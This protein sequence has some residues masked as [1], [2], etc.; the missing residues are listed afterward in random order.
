MCR[1]RCY[2][3]P[4]RYWGADPLMKDPVVGWRCLDW[5]LHTLLWG[6]IIMGLLM[7]WG[8]EAHRMSR[9]MSH[10]CFWQEGLVARTFDIGRPARRS[11]TWERAIPCS[12]KLAFSC[13]YATGRRWPSLCCCYWQCCWLGGNHRSDHWT[14]C[15]GKP[16][17]F[18][19]VFLLG[20]SVNPF[21]ARM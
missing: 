17:L 11:L 7:L 2:D 6:L 3:A 14:E 12:G 20:S 5:R 1:W 15:K 10:R 13:G 21:R 18:G 8:K 4:Q 16:L 19:L 9:C